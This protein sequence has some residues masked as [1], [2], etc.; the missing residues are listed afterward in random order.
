MNISYKRDG[1]PIPALQSFSRVACL[2]LIGLLSACGGGSDANIPGFA[3]PPPVVIVPP[4]PPPPP[5]PGPILPPATAKNWCG[6]NQIQ[7]LTNNDDAEDPKVALGQNGSAI[8]VWNQRY[9]G[10]TSIRA[11]RYSQTNHWG[12][13]AVISDFVSGT[14]AFG[15][16]ISSDSSGNMMSVWL[17]GGSV[18]ASRFTPTGGWSTQQR[19][20]TGL[21]GSSSPQLSTGSDG[22]VMAVWSQTDGANY[23]I[24]A[25]RFTPAGG[26]GTAQLIET[27][28][29][30]SAFSPRLVSDSSGNVMAVWQQSDGIRRNIWANRFTLPS[31]T[32]TGVWGAAQLIETDNSG[33]AQNPQL[34]VTASGQVVAAWLLY[35][36]TQ[37]V[38]ST[39]RY[40]PGV[41]WGT[42]TQIPT[43]AVEVN[44]GAFTV[45]SNG[46]VLAVWNQRDTTGSLYSMWSVRFD[47]STG[48][49][50]PQLIETDNVSTVGSPS[51]A[52]DGY[53]N[54]I[55]VWVQ[56]N[57]SSYQVKTNRY[58]A[59]SGWGTT[60][61]LESSNIYAVYLGLTVDTA[62]N[63]MAVWA[64]EDGS[65]NKRIY[66]NAYA[67]T[68]P[69]K[70]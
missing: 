54:S 31:G 49:G 41:G 45:D 30:G 7:T 59:A 68:C 46:H 62:G 17:Q 35:N 29:A 36:G 70:P 4:P 22:N 2:A 11:R 56:R 21:G 32:T 52:S 5:P 9:D 40:T 10:F 14:S 53:G 24:W 67:S 19:I 63:A 25:N 58:T 13:E 16:Q 64:Q 61:S 43:G 57:G 55:V 34:G 6:A 69:V 12:D 65:E 39:N 66:A 28:D 50:S 26:W 60:Q 27:D 51:I 42:A 44:D 1:R 15:A 47:T 38:L 48:W 23:S 37:T 8:A 3:G 33:N 20:Q 18:W